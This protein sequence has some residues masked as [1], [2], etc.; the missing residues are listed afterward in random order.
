MKKSVKKDVTAFK[1]AN[2]DA[3]AHIYSLGV[4]EG[5]KHST[6]S[7]ETKSKFDFIEHEIKDLK[8]GITAVKEMGKEILE[9]VKKTN[10]RVTA[11]EMLRAQ[12]HGG[13]MVLKGIYGFIAVFLV[14]ATYALFNMYIEFQKLDG[15]IRG[16]VQEEIH[17][18][19][20][21]EMK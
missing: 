6:Q 15:T 4:A 2:P 16:I 1:K 8:D 20:L 9:Q 17:G 7:P 21:E 10:G 11:L 19:V 5:K 18:V 14:G 13:A 3:V 12:A